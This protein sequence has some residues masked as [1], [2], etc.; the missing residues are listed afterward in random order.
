MQP[1]F[2]G[3][4]IERMGGPFPMGVPST[5]EE[6]RAIVALNVMRE[7]ERC[8]NI[9]EERAARMGSDYNPC[10]VMASSIAK[11]IRDGI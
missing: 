5:V 6:L 1:E 7:R 10:A 9:A 3:E 11:E 8:A 4:L 2:L